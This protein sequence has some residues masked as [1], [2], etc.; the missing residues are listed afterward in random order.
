MECTERTLMTPVWTFYPPSSGH[1]C[2]DYHV[3]LRQ[4]TALKKKRF[5]G[6]CHA[7]KKSGCNKEV[8]VLPRWP[9]GGFSLYFIF[10]DKG[11][12]IHK[13]SLYFSVLGALQISQIMVYRLAV[14]STRPCSV[15]LH[16]ASLGSVSAHLVSGHGARLSY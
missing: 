15:Q 2:F 12:G 3:K 13:C 5:G 1:A 14:P 6:F 10:L 16:T 8:T 11:K 4:N 7:A 9:Y